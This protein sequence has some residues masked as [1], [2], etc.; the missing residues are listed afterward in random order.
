MK[1][2]SPASPQEVFPSSRQAAGG[3]PRRD[4]GKGLASPQM[5]CDGAEPALPSPD[6][7]PGG[8]RGLRIPR[9]NAPSHA[10][11]RGHHL[12]GSQHTALG[13]TLGPALP[14]LRWKSLG[15]FGWCASDHLLLPTPLG[16]LPKPTALGATPGSPTPARSPR[17]A[18]PGPWR[19]GAAGSIA[20]LRRRVW[21]AQR[22]W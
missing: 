1:E 2:R 14:L 15:H 20:C 9:H 21:T 18:S 13:L 10:R 5:G 12:H 6:A 7:M 22:P 8:S 16:L 3:F 17:H 11:A 4:D 19:P